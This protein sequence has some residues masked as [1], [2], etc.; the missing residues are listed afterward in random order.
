MIKEALVVLEDPE[1]TPLFTPDSLAEVPLCGVV[2]GRVVSGQVD[3]MAVG[4]DQV[5]VVDYKSNRMSPKNGEAVP[6]V[7]L[8]QMA[9]YRALCREIYPDKE[10]RCALLWTQVP[11]LMPLKEAELDRY[12]P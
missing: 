11:V 2:N 8:K 12:A 4:E 10:I 7:Y 6:E 1:F 3:R 5:L 9:A